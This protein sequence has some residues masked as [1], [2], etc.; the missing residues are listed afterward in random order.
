MAS[1]IKTFYFLSVAIGSID[2][3]NVIPRS[4]RKRT[5]ATMRFLRLREQRPKQIS[6]VFLS[7]LKQYFQKKFECESV[8]W[9][10]AINMCPIKLL[11]YSQI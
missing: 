5:S 8:E 1:R 10:S 6:N 3:S 2:A 7:R 11:H 9:F 4:V